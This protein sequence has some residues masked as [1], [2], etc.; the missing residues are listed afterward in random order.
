VATSTRGDGPGVDGESLEI[1]ERK[2]KGLLNKLTMERFDTISDQIIAWANKSKREKDGRTLKQVIKLVLEIATDEETYSEMYARL[3]RKMMEQ[4]SSKVQDDGITNA[5]GKPFA[6]S[7]LFRKYLL[8]RCQEDFERGWAA[9]ETTAAATATKPT[10]DKGIKKKKR[11]KKQAASEKTKGGGFELYSDEYFAAAKA[12]RRGLARIHFIGELF[13]LQMLTERIMH[14]CIKKLLANVKSPDDEEVECLC[15]LLMQVGSVL[16]TQTARAHFDMYFLCM[17]ELTKNKNVSV[18]ITFLLQD[19][20]ELRERK[21]VPRNGVAT[22]TTTPTTIAE[23]HE[24]AP[25]ERK[26]QENDA[27]MLQNAS[28]SP[29][30]DIAVSAPSG[31]TAQPR[32]TPVGE[33]SKLSTPSVFGGGLDD[34]AAGGTGAPTSATLSEAAAK[35]KIEEDTKEFFSIRM[36]DEAESY[37]SSLPMEHRYALV[38]ALVMKSIEMKEPDVI[39]VSDLFVRVREK[40]LCSPGGFEDGFNG[41]AELLDD[42][43]VDIPRAWLYFAILLRGSGLD[44]DEERRGRI[45]E[46]TKDPDKLN[47]LL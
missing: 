47:R 24:L 46:K 40:E 5:E 25:K 6:G 12:K 44:Q 29:N 27:Y 39:L 11:S 37:F 31:P 15:K 34:E 1:V 26:A 10:E 20:I 16:D 30:V 8:N 42:L 43:A 4:I 19:V 17:R 28:M 18:R 35:A 2:V 21:W 14:E 22:P 7:Q 41:L 13:K 9:K 32:S 3:C 36:L 23:V 38:D 33:E 45:A